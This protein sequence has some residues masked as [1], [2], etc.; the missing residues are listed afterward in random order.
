[1]QVDDAGEPHLLQ[2]HAGLEAACAVVADH[3]D[4]GVRFNSW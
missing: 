2:K 3:D 4:V 1:M